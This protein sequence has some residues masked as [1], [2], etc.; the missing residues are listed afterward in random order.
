MKRIIK[1][2]R[3][4][5]ATPPRPRGFRRAAGDAATVFG[6]VGQAVHRKKA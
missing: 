2:N 6:R 3:P 5:L 4:R 1:Q